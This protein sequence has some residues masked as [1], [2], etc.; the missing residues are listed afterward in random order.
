MLLYTNPHSSNSRRVTMTALLLDVPL[1]TRLVKNMK[2]PAERAALLEVN[3]NGK[4]PVLVDGD[5]VLWESCAIMQYLAELTPDQTLY[6]IELEARLD[7]NRWL[8]WCVQ[9]WAPA[10]GVLNWENHIK[11]MMGFGPTN[12]LEVARG[13]AETARFAQVLD[14]HL[15][16]RQ[17]VSGDSLTLADIAL[18]TPLASSVPAKMPVAQYEHL[19]AWFAQVRGLDAWRRTQP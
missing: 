11:P 14:E 9:H 5:F 7:V 4:V 15:A 3:P 19:Q 1:E 2:D 16:G 6:P 10:L 18:A 17:W 13:E 12:A 8:F